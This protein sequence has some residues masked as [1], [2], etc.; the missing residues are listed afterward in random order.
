MNMGIAIGAVAAAFFATRRSG[1]LRVHNLTTANPAG[2]KCLQLTGSVTTLPWLAAS[3][4]L[5]LF[6]LF[7]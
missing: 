6:R 3:L 2:E 5:A 1:K 4:L 7:Y